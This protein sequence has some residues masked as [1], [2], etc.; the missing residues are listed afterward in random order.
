MLVVC[1]NKSIGRILRGMSYGKFGIIGR[2][3]WRNMFDYW[4]IIGRW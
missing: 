3:V 1:D 4:R 2:I